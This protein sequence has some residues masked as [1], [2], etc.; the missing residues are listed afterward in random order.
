MNTKIFV[1]SGKTVI[2]CPAYLIL[3]NRKA[4]KR[5][6]S[7][8]RLGRGSQKRNSS[9]EKSNEKCINYHSDINQPTTT[10]LL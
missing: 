1:N 9:E 3:C 5:N 8:S 2:T 4:K 6:N 10:I 7:D